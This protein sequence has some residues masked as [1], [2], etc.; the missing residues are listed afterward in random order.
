M[1]NTAQKLTNFVVAH[2]RPG[3]MVDSKSLRI[4]GGC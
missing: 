4:S 3:V 2:A 1:Q